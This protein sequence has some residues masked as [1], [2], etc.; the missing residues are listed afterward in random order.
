[1]SDSTPMFVVVEILRWVDDYQPGIVECKL[2]DAAGESHLF[3]EKSPIVSTEDLWSHT[4]YP[5]PGAIDCTL[6]ERWM[7]EKGRQLSRIDTSR[8]WH[9]ESTE[10]CTSF[11]VLE[12]QLGEDSFLRTLNTQKTPESR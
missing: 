10:G 8:P 2:V 6:L 5:R 12:S 11:V 7:D 1:M 9:V 3:I 4:T